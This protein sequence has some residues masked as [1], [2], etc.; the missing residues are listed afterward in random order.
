M[1]VAV[2]SAV[3]GLLPFGGE[4]L[5][6]RGVFTFFVVGAMLLKMALDMIDVESRSRHVI[7]DVSRLQREE[8]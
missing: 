8:G 1:H 4:M 3:A 7:E 5:L 6:R 2:F